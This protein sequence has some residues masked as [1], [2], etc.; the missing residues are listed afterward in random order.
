MPPSDILPNMACPTKITL[1]G[2]PLNG[3]SASPRYSV[4][5]MAIYGIL[6]YPD[7]GWAQK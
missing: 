7:L 3:I 2:D 4:F 1:S 5:Q 6:P